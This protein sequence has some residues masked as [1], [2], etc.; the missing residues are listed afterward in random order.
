MYEVILLDTEERME[1]AVEHLS[2]EFRGIRSGRATP[3]LV[4]NIR[5]DYYGTMQPLKA[6]ASIAIRQSWWSS[7]P[8][9]CTASTSK[10]R[11]S[12]GIIG[13][14]ACDTPLHLVI[15][16]VFRDNPFTRRSP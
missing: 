15:G 5:V 6:T 7:G 12:E 2:V 4:E 1:K 9:P 10:T 13:R 14:R 16:L 3:G 8:A 11:R